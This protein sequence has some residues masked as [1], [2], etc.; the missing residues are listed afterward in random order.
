[1]YYVSNWVTRQLR[2]SIGSTG[3]NSRQ[4]YGERGPYY[5]CR[6]GTGVARKIERKSFLLRRAGMSG[7]VIVRMNTREYD[8]KVSQNVNSNRRS[9]SSVPHITKHWAWW[10]QRGAIGLLYISRWLTQAHACSYL[11]LP[12]SSS[13]LGE[14]KFRTVHA[15]TWWTLA[16]SILCHTFRDDHNIFL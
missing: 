14:Q 1:M 2:H 13:E 4:E 5:C 9:T 11:T 6:A 16:S 8:S 3:S 15:V 7:A 12:T 10:S